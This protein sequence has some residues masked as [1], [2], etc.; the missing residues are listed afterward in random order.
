[1]TANA[2]AQLRR[3]LNLIPHLA[4]GETHSVADVARL[5]DVDAET[6]FND[7]KS[8]AGRFD[9]PGGF[10]EGVQI[11]LEAE[12]LSLRSDHF[13]RPMRLTAPELCALE[14]G[15]AMLRAERPRGEH[16]AIDRARARLRQTLVGLSG[17][18]DLPESR[19]A[20][21]SALGGEQLATLREAY[22][23]GRKVR[24]RYRKGGST[25]VSERVTCPFAIVAASGAWYVVAHCEASDAVRIFRLDR[26][27]S[28][29]LLS[30]R[31]RIPDG[32][33]VSEVLAT[34]RMWMG[35]GA[36]QLRVRYSPRIARWIAERE[37]KSLDADGSLTMEHPMG[38][39]EWAVRHVLQYG[40]EAE[41]LGPETVRVE[42][43]SRLAALGA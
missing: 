22:R 17:E 40:A 12:R 34:G 32:F 15:L 33:S 41:V 19:H 27:E 3:L 30:E 42:L 25:D 6:V 36:A 1:M 37:G 21:I 2:A 26:I 20:S 18:R 7:L 14:L 43:A 9:D 11:F 8:L 16:D 4:D 31:Y 23:T 38:D 39:A 10:V 29:E 24:L 35:A 13:N 28:A 5:T